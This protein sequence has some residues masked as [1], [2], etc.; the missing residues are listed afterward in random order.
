M[1]GTHIYYVT[2]IADLSK[3]QVTCYYFEKMAVLRV[4]W[5][6]LQYVGPRLP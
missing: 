3:L 5:V 1:S 4:R 6:V 2:D